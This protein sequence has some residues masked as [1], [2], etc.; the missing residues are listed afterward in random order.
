MISVTDQMMLQWGLALLLPFFRI[1]GIFTSAPIIS[2][3][4]TP[5]RLRIALALAVAALVA[6][7]LPVP[8]QAL[9]AELVPIMVREVI[10]GLLI[11]FLARVVFTAF[12]IAGEAI[13]LQM[14]LSFAGFF[15]PQSGASNPVARLINMIALT[16]FAALNGHALL[17]ST[18]MDSFRQLPIGGDWHWFDGQALVSFGTLMFSLGLSVALP[19]MVLLL[20]LNLALGIMSRVAPQF[21]IFSIGFPVTISCGLILLALAV[22]MLDVPINQ[23]F[24]SLSALVP[25]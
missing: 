17:V 6:P 8:A 10:I 1:L 25:R 16:G 23:A 21:S 13:G 22:P 24:E 4:S 12:E 15:D 5:A 7:S 19:F 11:G 18:I 9:G 3:R 2:A 20:F 14:G